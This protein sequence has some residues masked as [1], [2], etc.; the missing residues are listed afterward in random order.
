MNACCH[1]NFEWYS[2]RPICPACGLDQTTWIRLATA[3]TD[4][5]INHLTGDTMTLPIKLLDGG[6][7]PTRAH[8]DDAG[9][10]CYATVTRWI[11]PDSMPVTIPLG[12]A[13]AIP[14]G[15]M[16]ILTLR[17]SLGAEGLSI[18]HAFGVIDAGYRG[19]VMAK[20]IITRDDG[21]R[22]E[23][24]DRVCQL[25]IVPILTPDVEIVDQLPPSGDGRGAGGFG[26]SG[27]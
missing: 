1:D 7:A 5:L 12:F 27:R 13:T 8:A 9:L 26:S 4:T 19:E 10:D 25:S 2:A 3:R 6:K 15:H 17:S 23:R 11:E 20:L 24:G 18:P 21:Y 16:G 22:I 14:R